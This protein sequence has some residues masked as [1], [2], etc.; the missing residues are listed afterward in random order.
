MPFE[1]LNGIDPE[2]EAIYWCAGYAAMFAAGYSESAAG[3]GCAFDFARAE[4]CGVS[5]LKV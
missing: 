5:P 4:L 1:A 2:R 3:L